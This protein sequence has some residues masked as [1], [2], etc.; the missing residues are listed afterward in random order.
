MKVFVRTASVTI[1]GYVNAVERNSKPLYERGVRFIERIASG[2]FQR[3][4]NRASSIKAL[5]N[6]NKMHEIGNTSDDSLELAEDNIGLR[7]K[8]VTSDPETVKD[9]K[10]GDLVGCSFGFRE[11][12]G[13][14]SQ[15]IDPET[16]LPLKKINNLEL[17]EISLLNRKHTPAYQGTLVE[18]RETGEEV[19]SSIFYSD[20]NEE[21][22][23]LIRMIE[24]EEVLPVVDK[25]EEADEAVSIR[26]EE[27]PKEE[28][29]AEE[30]PQVKEVS[31]DYY[32]RYKN[33]IAEMKK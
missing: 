16:G 23:E 26:E 5:L 21:E 10:N 2:A 20:T 22:V 24:D 4:I 7:F 18:V 15:M 11:I 1:E 25:V 14:T 33:M 13:E 28:A 17:I 3:A 29:V 30:A 27:S 31:S 12:P 32:A 9:A 6:H 8:L 19:E